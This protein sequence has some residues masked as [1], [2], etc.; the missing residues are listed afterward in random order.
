MRQPILDSAIILASILI[1]GCAYSGYN[2]NETDMYPDNGFARGYSMVGPGTR[3]TK[4]EPHRYEIY[5]RTTWFVAPRETAREM[6]ADRANVV[7]GG[8]NYVERDV[9]EHDVFQKG[10]PFDLGLGFWVSI[11]IG[12]VECLGSEDLYNHGSLLVGWDIDSENS[13]AFRSLM[14][15]A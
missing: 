10:N 11:K 4:L 1:A 12:V 15:G 9:A 8:D 3:A 6:W 7:C 5:A 2:L 13:D 14:S